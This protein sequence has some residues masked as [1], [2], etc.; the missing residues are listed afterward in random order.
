ME[1]NIKM[2]KFKNATNLVHPYFQ[3]FRHRNVIQI[4]CGDYHTLFLVAGA[5]NSS[6]FANFEVM[7]IG[8]NTVGQILGKPSKEIIKEPLVIFELSGKK[9]TGITASR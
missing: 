4:A 7:G 5:I 1:Y 8:E 9:I 3:Q 2:S 6:S